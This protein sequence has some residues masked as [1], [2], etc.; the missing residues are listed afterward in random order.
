V[1]IKDIKDLILQSN[2]IISHTLRD[3]NQCADY[4]TK[5]GVSTNNDLLIYDAPPEGLLNL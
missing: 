1:L 5:L 3:D 4:L 2:V